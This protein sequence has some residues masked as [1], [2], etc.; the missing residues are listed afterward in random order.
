MIISFNGLDGSGKS[1]QIENIHKKYYSN[2]K[3]IDDFY[4]SKRVKSDCE[5]SFHNWWFKDSTVEEFCD[6][7]YNGIKKRISKIKDNKKVYLIDKGISNFDARI[8]A[9]LRLKGLNKIESLNTMK[10]Y[11][12]KY[13]LSDTENIRILISNK[14]KYNMKVDN[15]NYTSEQIT[16]YRKY[17]SYQKEFINELVEH[18]YF[19][20]IYEMKGTIDSLSKKIYEDIQKYSTEYNCRTETISI[21]SLKIPKREKKIITEIKNYSKKVLKDNLSGILIHGSI[22][23]NEY[24][25]NWSD[26][27]LLIFV[28]SYDLSKLSQINQFIK[29]YDIKIGLTVFSNYELA[30]YMLDAKS[31][32][33]VYSFNSGKIDS[34]I[35]SNNIFLPSLSIYNLKDKNKH[36][37]P[38]TIHKLKRYLYGD[39]NKNNFKEIYK[40]LT[41]VMKVDLINNHDIISKSYYQ[42]FYNFS[43]IYNLDIMDANEFIVNN[44]SEL[45]K[46][47]GLKVINIISNGGYYE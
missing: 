14:S 41:L 30:N 33:S 22:S 15:K 8:Y 37:I 40:M 21:S 17:R 47:F 20:Y 45:L 42:T 43:Y 23:R 5:E 36:V 6:A 2:G 38:E 1:T 4:F 34:L 39:I 31:L 25:P 7:M 44:N 3:L 35:Y 29:Q 19:T 12:I 28:H 10:K 32:Y 27:D 16:L 18:N 9:T 26:I 24:I 13:K 11:K 46:E